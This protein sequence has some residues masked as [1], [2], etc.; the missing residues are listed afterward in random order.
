MIWTIETVKAELPDV[1]V[2]IAQGLTVGVLRGR[3]LP[4]AKLSVEYRP[5]IWTDRDIDWRLLVDA[6]NNGLVCVFDGFQ[7]KWFAVKMDGDAKRELS[8]HPT[9]IHTQEQIE[10]LFNG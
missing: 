4:M 7:F 1:P 3:R 10:N 8:V 5:G 9:A 6:L 2:R